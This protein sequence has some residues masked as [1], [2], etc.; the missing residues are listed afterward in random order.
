MIFVISDLLELELI[1]APK[2]VKEL[3]SHFPV[4]YFERLNFNEEAEELAKIYI[5]EKV[6]GKTSIEDCRHIALATISK[7]DILA[8]WNF[9]NIVNLERIKGYNSI[10]LRRG[11]PMIE[12]RSPQEL[13]IYED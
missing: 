12:I 3:L 1:L 13:I 2:H 6:V 11:Y 5:K 9:K 8:S 7:I 4:K 10:N